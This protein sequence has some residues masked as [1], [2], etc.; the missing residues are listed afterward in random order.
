MGKHM[1]FLVIIQARCGATRLP[2]K[3]LKT[4]QDKTCLEL[5]LNRVSRSKMI[6]EIIVA[7]TINKED[8]KIANLI[9][10]LGYRVFVGSSGDVLDRYYQCAKLIKPEYV[11]RLTADCPLFDYRV[12]DEAI[13]ELKSDTDYLTELSETF[14]DGQDIEIMK[15]SV[16]KDAWENADMASEREHV[17]LYIRNHKEKY[18]IQDFVC[19]IGNLNKERWTLDEP[20][21]FELISNV[22]NYFLPNMD[23]TMEDVYNYLQLHPNI[24]SINNMINRNEGLAKSIFEDKKVEKG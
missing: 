16:L 24:H 17:T 2:N 7:T 15:F 13:G 4:I 6:D 19:K 20:K 18:K 1:K 10:S 14:P 21:D 12:L 22:Y 9:T 11:I 3:V 5:M 8:I 23:F